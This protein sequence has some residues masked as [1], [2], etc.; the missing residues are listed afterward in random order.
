MTK[1][2]PSPFLR[3]RQ[4]AVPGCCRTTASETHVHCAGHMPMPWDEPDCTCGLAHTA[5]CPEHGDPE[6]GAGGD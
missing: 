6:R 4:C 1:H 3:Q 2:N 5:Y